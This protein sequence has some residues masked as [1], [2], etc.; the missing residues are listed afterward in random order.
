MHDRSLLPLGRVVFYGR[1]SNNLFGLCPATSSFWTLWKTSSNT[2]DP[3]PS[4]SLTTTIAF[5]LGVLLP[6]T[7]LKNLHASDLSMTLVKIRGIAAS[8]LQKVCIQCPVALFHMEKEVPDRFEITQFQVSS[9]GSCNLTDFLFSDDLSCSF[10]TLIV[11]KF[12]S[13]RN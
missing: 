6:T 11:Q 13:L 7:L 2:Q 5:R 4:T 9:I 10:F 12:S 3:L 1:S 8:G